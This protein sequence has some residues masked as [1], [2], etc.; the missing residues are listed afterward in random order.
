ML[1]SAL[2]SSS[3][4]YYKGIAAYSKALRLNPLSLNA[5]T[6]LSDLFISQGKKDEAIDWYDDC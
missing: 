5:A 2:Q 4:S 3:S 1:S 6:Y